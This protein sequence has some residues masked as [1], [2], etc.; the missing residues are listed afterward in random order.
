MHKWKSIHDRFVRLNKK[1]NQVHSGAPG[2]DIVT[3]DETDF[4]NSMA[5]LQGHINR[6]RRSVVRT[7][8]TGHKKNYRMTHYP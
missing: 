2:I 1:Q 3:W 8:F 7:E 5:F 4:V 6:Q